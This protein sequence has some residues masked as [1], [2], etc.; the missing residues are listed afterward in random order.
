MYWRWWRC[1]KK[2]RRNEW[3]ASQILADGERENHFMLCSHYHPIRLFSDEMYAFRAS[4]FP[5]FFIEHTYRL[6]GGL[7]IGSNVYIST[8]IHFSWSPPSAHTCVKKLV[9]LS[10]SLLFFCSLAHLIADTFFQ[11]QHCLE[12]KS[13]NI[14]CLCVGSDWQ[15]K[16]K[17]SFFTCIALLLLFKLVLV[18]VKKPRVL[19]L[20]GR[21]KMMKKCR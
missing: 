8:F 1:N 13:R 4:F 9:V 15:H 6:F 20:A 2:K 21:M 16:E 7:Y 19:L 11:K 10:F 12:G 17:I 14:D 3:E 18:D 5:F